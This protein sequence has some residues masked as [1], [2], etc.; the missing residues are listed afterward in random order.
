MTIAFES[1]SRSSLASPTS[2]QKPQQQQPSAPGEGAPTSP[3]QAVPTRGPSSTSQ[4]AQLVR[5]QAGEALQPSELQHLAGWLREMLQQVEGALGLGALSSTESSTVLSTAAVDS[6]PAGGLQRSQHTSSESS[7]M[8]PPSTAVAP[9][10]G[11]AEEQATD[12]RAYPGPAGAMP[13]AVFQAG[14]QH[15][16]GHVPTLASSSPPTANSTASY[17]GIFA[18]AAAG[19]ARTMHQVR[20]AR[21][22]SSTLSP[23]ARMAW[24]TSGDSTLRLS[25]ASPQ[26]LVSWMSG[27]FN[28]ERLLGMGSAELARPLHSLD[29]STK[30]WEAGKGTFSEFLKDEVKEQERARLKQELE[31][32]F[33]PGSSAD[34][35]GE[36]EMLGP[37]EG[38]GKEDKEDAG[39]TLPKGQAPTTASE[40]WNKLPAVRS[41][42]VADWDERKGG[43]LCEERSDLS[44]SEAGG[45]SG[46][47][48]SSSA[49]TSSRVQWKTWNKAGSSSVSVQHSGSDVGN[50]LPGS[51]KM[52]NSMS[53]HS[54]KGFGDIGCL[55]EEDD[56]DSQESP[57]CKQQAPAATL[58]SQSSAKVSKH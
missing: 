27:G 44:S 46:H 57:A 15:S 25:M 16:R 39:S 36:P 19:S 47:S 51:G 48:S 9:V 45:A 18:A 6:L 32:L 35:T 52:R 13:S 8:E 33:G 54:G 28:D 34:N 53:I 31:D 22:D 4:L 41:G 10:S 26:P 5:Y 2:S 30:G 14:S 29:V 20:F 56:E 37:S 7:S 43:A 12:A 17:S 42:E 3:S 58:K 50:D 24:T 40:K 23:E 1:Q 55:E 38:K 11:E 21:L 49:G